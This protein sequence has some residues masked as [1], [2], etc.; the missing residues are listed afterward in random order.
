LRIRN[1]NLGRFTADRLIS[2]LNRLGSRV[3][4]KV[5]LVRA[6][7]VAEEARP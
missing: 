5:R 4:V 1:A 7:P 2:I 3:E 6:R